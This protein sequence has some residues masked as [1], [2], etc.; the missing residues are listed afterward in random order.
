MTISEA[1]SKVQELIGGGM[2]IPTMLWGPPGIGK[3]SIIK[4]VAKGL[5]IGFID[6]RLSLLNPVDLRG[7]PVVDHKEYKARWL[8][9]EFLPNGKDE[10]EGI[11]F[12]DEINLAPLSVQAAAYQLI[13]D[14]RLGNYVLPEGWN[15]VAAGNREVDQANVVKFPAPLANRFIHIEIEPEI[16]SWKVW[17]MK[18]GMDERVIAF[19]TKLPQHLFKMPKAGEKTFPTPRT[20]EY[21][22]SMKNPE[23][24]YLAVGE[25]VAAEYNAFLDVYKKMPDIDGILSGKIKPTMFN[26]YVPKENDVLFALSTAL[27]VRCKK[28]NLDNFFGYVKNLPKD[29]EVLSVRALLNKLEEQDIIFEKCWQ[30]WVKENE[31]VYKDGN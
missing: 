8:E 27:A 22:S 5:K 12:L 14:R 21:V 7:L 26:K 18:N 16:D 19:L 30:D 9:P 2:K 29:F 24:A 13:L 1:K 3:S 10:K 20:W 6:L 17:A 15:I 11:L 25:G 28:E 31:E 23:D 4:Q